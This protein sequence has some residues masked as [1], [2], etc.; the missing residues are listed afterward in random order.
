MSHEQYDSCIKGCNECATACENCAASCLHEQDIKKMARCIET[1]RD[2]ADICSLA[3]RYMSRGSSFAG[4][5]CA[6]CAEIC[7]ACGDECGKHKMEHCQ[8][9]AKACRTCAEECRKMAKK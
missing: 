3:T 1:D 7:Q 2:C 8:Q 9:C 6:L 5:R 4:K